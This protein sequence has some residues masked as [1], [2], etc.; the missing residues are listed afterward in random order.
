MQEFSS[1]GTFIRTF[2]SSA[3]GEGQ[4]LSLLA[5]WRSIQSGNVWV[6]DTLQ[7]TASQEFSATGT[8]L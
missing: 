6:L 2:G 3:P 7:A 4:L 1:S 5:P 8:Y